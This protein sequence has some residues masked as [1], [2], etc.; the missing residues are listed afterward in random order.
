[1]GLFLIRVILDKLKKENKNMNTTYFTGSLFKEDQNDD[2]TLKI[3]KKMQNEMDQGNLVILSDLEKA[4]PSLYELFNQNFMIIDGKQY[5][6]IVLGF[7]NNQYSHVNE[8]F[9]CIIIVDQNM[10]NKQQ[11]PF[12]NRFEKHQISFEFLLKEETKQIS[13]EI[14]NIITDLI[15][16]NNY[17]NLNDIIFN[18][19]KEEIQ[20]LVYIVH[21][22]NL[23]KEKIINNLLSK[24]FLTFPQ[25]IFVSMNFS[26]FIDRQKEI[27]NLFISNYEK[28]NNKN[29]QQC[30][31]FSFIKNMKTPK[32]L[33]YTFSNIIE[34]ISFFEEKIKNENFKDLEEIQLNNIFAIFVSNINS[35]NELE[36]ALDDFYH[37]ETKK[38]FI[39]KFTRKE[40]NMMNP[41]N[42]N[43][44]N[45][46]DNNMNMMKPMIP[47]IP[48][49]INQMGNINI[50]NPNNN[51][52]INSME[53]SNM[54]NPMNDNMM[55]KMGNNN[56]MKNQMN[57]NLNNNVMIGN[58]M[59]PISQF[60][61]NRMT[62][63]N[64][65]L[66]SQST[67]INSMTD[68]NFNRIKDIIK[69]YEE[70]IKEQEELIRKNT[71]QIV[72][73]KEKLKQKE[74]NNNEKMNNPMGMM[75]MN[76]NA[77]INSD[78]DLMEVTFQYGMN[79]VQKI[80]CLN[81]ELIESVFNRYCKKYFLNRYN[82]EFSFMGSDIIN[83]YMTVS[84]FGLSNNSIIY[85]RD[86]INLGMFGMPNNFNFFDNLNNIN[87]INN[88]NNN[89]N[90]DFNNN[91][92]D[93]ELINII[94]TYKGAKSLIFLSENSTLSDALK[95]FLRRQNISD[96]DSKYLTF[97]NNDKKIFLGDSR[98]LKE[99]FNGMGFITVM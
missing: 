4:Y 21:K 71:F 40:I 30:N 2:Y 70:K 46:F 3:L 10:I 62:G 15:D 8:N 74:K 6:R 97:L 56:N 90:N 83:T 51:I 28:N 72:L 86:K 85:V 5:T 96:E 34:Q 81:D 45:S 59:M 42:N 67:E 37:T 63:T 7:S 66:M 14:Y 76:Y 99:V 19:D 82:L 20:G 55:N 27:A 69:P 43:M 31:L 68:E 16:I 78:N 60:D 24:F 91:N 22:E 64:T 93:K 73:L 75:K 84:D 88:F 36:L 61:N 44:V 1:M 80:K 50:M 53:N 25:D 92:T 49:N 98:K 38:I 41:I 58:N 23:P 89:P 54:M 52:K 29:Y 9:K 13:D 18:C 48:L 11:P 94:F 87:N 26:G 57:F 33:I 95:E 77:N 79:N 65:L 17:Y 35:E 12:I 39:L 47:V 32:N